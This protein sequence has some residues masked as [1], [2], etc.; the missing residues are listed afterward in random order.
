MRQQNPNREQIR[1]LDSK[2]MLL[3]CI[4]IMLMLYAACLTGLASNNAMRY[5]IQIFLYII[6][7]EMWNLLSG[8]AGMTSLGQQLYIGLSGYAV[9]VATTVFRMP[10]GVGILL[11]VVICTLIALLLSLLLFRMEGMYFSIATWVVAEAFAT[12]FLSWE[13]VGRGS[14][15]TI[16]A[17]PYPQLFDICLLSLTVCIAALAVVYV[18]LRTRAGLGLTAMRDDITA[19][20]SVG[21]DQFRHKLLVYI[22]SAVFIAFAGGIFVIN[23]GIIYP[24]NGF[25]ISWT[26]SMIFIVV[27]GGKGTVSGPIVGAVIYV[28]LQEYLAHYPGWSNIILGVITIVAILFLPDGVMGTLQKKLRFEIFSAKRVSFPRNR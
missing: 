1:V 13:F 22:I 28:F 10:L 24:E 17:N 3:I 21:V 27:I 23:K 18:L 7:G 19:A 8:Y 25:S 26:V 20:S 2:P 12:F 4:L 15:M 16:R 5:M 9:A 14:G 11:G 6:M